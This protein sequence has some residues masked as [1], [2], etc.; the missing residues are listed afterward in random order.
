[1]VFFILRPEAK[2]IDC[3]QDQQQ[4]DQPPKRW[5][6]AF[7]RA[8]QTIA[9]ERR[10]SIGEGRLTSF[11][12][13]VQAAAAFDRNGHIRM[14]FD[15]DDDK[16]NISGLQEEAKKTQA[17]SLQVTRPRGGGTDLN[18]P[19]LAICIM[20]VGTHGDVQPFVAIAKTR[21]PRTP[22]YPRRLS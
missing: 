22:R 19:S 1:M 15:D 2:T 21:P 12:D 10:Q 18:V 8:V 13:V 16:Y 4:L 17:E 9:E 3:K 20:I 5:K 6:G 11:A 14:D 7:T